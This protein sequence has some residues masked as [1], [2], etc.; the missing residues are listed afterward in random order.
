MLVW[1]QTI[2]LNVTCSISKE[3]K[4]SIRRQCTAQI[5]KCIV[6]L[7]FF[8]PFFSKEDFGNVLYHYLIWFYHRKVVLSGIICHYRL[9][10]LKMFY[11]KFQ[12]GQLSPTPNFACIVLSRWYFLL[13]EILKKF[14]LC[15]YPLINFYF[16]LFSRDLGSRV[17]GLVF[18]ISLL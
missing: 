8:V 12:I 1:F 15:G 14:Q 9:M 6:V 18:L 13:V 3:T 10:K 5:N 16:L 11:H 4:T 2:W 17:S 7:Y